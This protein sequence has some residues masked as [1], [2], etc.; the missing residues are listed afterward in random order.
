MH[1]KSQPPFRIIT[2]S[3]QHWCRPCSRFLVPLCPS[4]GPARYVLV[5]AATGGHSMTTWTR[6]GGRWSKKGLFCPGSYWMIP[7]ARS[8]VRFNIHVGVGCGQ[9][10]TKLCPRSHWMILRPL[11]R[12]VIVYHGVKFLQISHFLRLQIFKEG[13]FLKLNVGKKFSG[14]F[15]LGWFLY[16]DFEKWWIWWCLFV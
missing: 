11:P 16:L 12:W 8:T 5:V 9:K 7:C 15:P 10:R 14:W 3:I 13:S 1:N 4:A 2:A 6:R